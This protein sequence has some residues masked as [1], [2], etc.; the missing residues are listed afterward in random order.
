MSTSGPGFGISSLISD[1]LKRAGLD[2]IVKEQMCV[3]VWD[4]VV[5]K[6]VSDAA[7]PDFVK[8]G[9]LFVTT[10]SPVWA[11]ELTFYKQEMIE[12]LNRRAG[13]DALKDIVF[14]SGRFPRRAAKPV[15]E[16][17]PEPA[18]EGIALSEREL[19]SV[20]EAA[21]EAGEAR[22]DVKRLLRT[23]L[24]LEKWKQESGWTPCAKCGALE[25]SADGVCP[26]CKMTS[27]K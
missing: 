22:D 10:K 26:L 18:L 15:M 1:A 9:K 5:G 12:K 27:D 21:A 13:G 6:P 16:D 3:A 2:G 8:D 17:G 14:K 7:Q 24:R 19:E 11:N 4:E 25:N 23:A 20:D